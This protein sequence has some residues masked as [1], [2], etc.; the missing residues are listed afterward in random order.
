MIA[1]GVSTMDDLSGNKT[2]IYGEF[3]ERVRSF[4]TL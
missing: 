3:Y 1:A 2:G 4:T